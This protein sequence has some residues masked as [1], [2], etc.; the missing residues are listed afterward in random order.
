MTTTLRI[1]DT[2]KRQCDEVLA[3]LGLTMTNALT[4]FLKQVVRTRSIPFIIG[5]DSKRAIDGR[6]A[7]STFEKGRRERFANGEREWSM[8]EICAEIDDSHSPIE[9][10]AM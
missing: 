1:D 9:K 10:V 5:A 8:D 6:K 7:W 2:L 3:E 4:V